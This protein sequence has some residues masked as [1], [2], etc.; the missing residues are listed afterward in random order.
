MGPRFPSASG[1]INFPDNGTSQVDSPRRRHRSQ[2]SRPTCFRRAAA[3]RQAM[4]RAQLRL[5]VACA[6]NTVAT[7]APTDA[8]DASA[9]PR[10]L[11]D[12]DAAGSI[13]QACTRLRALWGV[14]PVVSVSPTRAHESG[15]ETGRRDSTAR[16]PRGDRS[17]RAPTSPGH[18][19]NQVA[20]VRSPEGRP[21]AR[22]AA[23]G[24]DC[25]ASPSACQGQ[26][27]SKSGYSTFV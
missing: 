18:C 6:G 3:H 12:P 16:P 26:A 5:G 21:V 19:R 11:D 2:R 22:V 1:A 4:A 24:D 8:S 20:L 15:L 13:W 23:A 14:F 7:P 10:Y 9:K 17:A 27:M 25:A